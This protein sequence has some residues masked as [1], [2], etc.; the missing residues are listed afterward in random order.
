M[1][2]RRGTQGRERQEG[3]PEAVFGA[4]SARRPVWSLGARRPV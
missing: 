4:R 3:R 1:S 2:A